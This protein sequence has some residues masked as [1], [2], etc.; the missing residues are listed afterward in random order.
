M[1][2]EDAA[3]TKRIQAAIEESR[4]TAETVETMRNA[5]RCRNVDF[6]KHCLLLFGVAC[7]AGRALV[8]QGLGL[9]GSWFGTAFV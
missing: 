2:Y 1:S 8:W 4:A 9:A 7:L 5:D 6:L 3:R